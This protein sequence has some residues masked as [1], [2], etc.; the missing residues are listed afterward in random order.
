MICVVL[1]G[2]LMRAYADPSI[3]A[4]CFSWR[5]PWRASLCKSSVC[6]L[7]VE[8]FKPQK[9]DKPEEKLQTKY[10]DWKKQETP[11]RS[12]ITVKIF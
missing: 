9:L 11:K 3:A 6:E 7:A 1:S 5:A 2:I 10:L 12:Y 8:Q 4:H